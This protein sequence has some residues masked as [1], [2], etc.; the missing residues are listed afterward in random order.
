[1]NNPKLYLCQLT[2]RKRKDSPVLWS[3]G[4]GRWVNDLVIQA[5]GRG[6]RPSEEENV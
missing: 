2:F 5:Y 6:L 3:D 1:M 4:V